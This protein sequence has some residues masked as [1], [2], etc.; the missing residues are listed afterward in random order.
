MDPFATLGVEPRFDL[1]PDELERRYRELS[2]AVHPDR[3]SAGAAS[4]R[5]AALSRS[6][7]INEAY[8]TLRDPIRR[9]EKLLELRGVAVGDGHEPKPSGAL[10]M[11]MM[12]AREALSEAGHAKDAAAIAQ[13]SA[14]MK[15]REAALLQRLG[16][17]LAEPGDDHHAT[18]LSLLGELRYTRRFLDEVAAFEELL[19]A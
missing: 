11:E 4:L 7:D 8:R 3:H 17:A 10:L 9:A 19:L 18:A 16:E 1:A 5:R 13:Q 14:A 15:A 2:R 6:M 12:E